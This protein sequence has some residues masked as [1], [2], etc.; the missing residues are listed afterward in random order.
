MPANSPVGR[1]AHLDAPLTNVAIKAFQSRAEFIAQKI[2]P[3]VPVGKQSDK[4]YVI[5]KQNFLS[6]PDT[7]RAPKT[8]PKRIE[9]QVSSNSYFCDNYALAGENAKEDLANADNAI[10]LR[11]NTVELVMDTLLRDFEVRVANTV[12]SGTNLGSYVSL[13][14][15]AKW[16]DSVN[17]DPI[18]DVTTA[19][20]FIRQ[21]TGLKANTMVIDEDT[22]HVIDRHPILMDMYKYTS[23]GRVS[24]EEIK[25]AFK[26]DNMFIG[27]GIKEN[28]LENA[29]SS[30][31]NIWGNNVILCRVVPGVSRQTQTFGLS[32]R[33]TPAGMPA[34][35][36]ARRYNDPDPGKGIEVVD[37]SYYQDEK[38]VATDLAYGILATL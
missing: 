9:F 12:T 19:H 10:M 23:G 20:A 36:V 1:G 24:F 8:S 32:F 5:D 16:S 2:F 33:W 26:V 37:V 34:P 18:S 35:M 13:T 7:L 22:L 25:K 29:T 27:Q 28:A 38:I 6:V 30:I 14:G 17:S 4:Y 21:N 3:V 15:T 31:T 11:E